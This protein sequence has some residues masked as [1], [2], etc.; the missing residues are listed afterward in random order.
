MSPPTPGPHTSDTSGRR[1]AA[2][3]TGF[4]CSLLI[5]RSMKTVHYKTVRVL[6]REQVLFYQ[7]SI[8]LEHHN[9]AVLISRPSAITRPCS[10]QNGGKVKPQYSSARTLQGVSLL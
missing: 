6:M 10:S 5:I 8:Y 9:D 7:H 1:F 4:P 3:S 2:Q